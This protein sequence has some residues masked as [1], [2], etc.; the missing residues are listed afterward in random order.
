LGI[1]ELLSDPNLEL[2]RGARSDLESGEVDRR[3]VAALHAFVRRHGIEVR[4]I[5]TGHP[6]GPVS[7]GGVV[8]DHY[9]YRAADIYRV[10]G[11]PVA[12]NETAP[13]LLDVG[14]ILR[15]LPPRAR[16]DLIMGPALWQEALACPQSAGFVNDGFHNEI[17]AD[18]L[19]LGFLHERGTANVT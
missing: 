6:M 5:R 18:H 3:L 13:A 14:G 2:S 9:Y 16:P 1:E 19:P 17:H 11:K 7:P 15:E 12:G 4:T 8:N 10:D